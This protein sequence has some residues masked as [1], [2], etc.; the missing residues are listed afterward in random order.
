MPGIADPHRGIAPYVRH[1]RHLDFTLVR[2]CCTRDELR[3]RYLRRGSPAE[4]LDEL[5]A[6]ADALDR[7]DVGVALDTSAMSPDEGADTLADHTAG[8]RPPDTLVPRAVPRRRVRWRGTGTTR[9]RPHR[10]R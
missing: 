6:V 1:A 10:C 4:R 3:R 9:G 5:M 7:N 2:L 8:R